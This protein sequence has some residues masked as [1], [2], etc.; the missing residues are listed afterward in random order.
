MNVVLMTDAQ[1]RREECEV[2]DLVDGALPWEAAYTCVHIIH[3]YVEV[4]VHTP[5]RQ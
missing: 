5:I 2:D 3:T 4:S 1:P